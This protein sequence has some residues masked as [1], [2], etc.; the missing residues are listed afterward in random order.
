MFLECKPKQHPNGTMVQTIPKLISLSAAVGRARG[1]THTHRMCRFP[2]C[3]R[4]P[5][6]NG[7]CEE[8]MEGY[9]CHC[10]AEVQGKHCNE[11][12]DEPPVNSLTDDDEKPVVTCPDDIIR[13]V[14]P[15]VTSLNVNFPN[16]TATDNSGKASL[17]RVTPPSGSLFQLGT[18]EVHYVFEDPSGNV[19]SCRFTVTVNG[20]ADDD[21]H[22]VVTCPDDTIRY[23]VPGV[24]SLNVTFPN[25]TATDNSGKASVIRVIPPSGS[26][27][28]LG[29]TEVHYVFEDPSWNIGACICTVS[30]TVNETAEVANMS[31]AL[32]MEN[33]IIPGSS[34]SASS[35]FDYFHSTAR[36]RLNL[37]RLAPYAGAWSARSHDV[38]PWIQVDLIT[39]YRINE[40]GT[41]G[42]EDLFQWVTSY[43][44]SCGID[45]FN[46]HIVK[47]S[48]TKPK[49]DKVFIGNIDRNTV[50]RNTLP[51]PAVCRY[52]RLVPITYH[53]HVSLRM[54]L[55]GYG[56]LTVGPEW[57]CT[58]KKCY[59]V[60]AG[61][62]N[63]TEAYHFCH[64]LEPVTTLAG[65]KRPSL[66]F[67]NTTKEY[68][69]VKRCS[70][71]YDKY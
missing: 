61:L 17:I 37:P 69:V 51:V 62:R 26:L 27:F 44:I 3:E 49:T 5:C 25:A 71:L 6:E 16:A 20:T 14:V 4:N 30:V 23:V 55:Y 31:Y 67:I 13:Y 42:R 9:K 53:K 63:W 2:D 11:H 47:N 70:Y 21:E 7:W 15:G 40:V 19:G 1:S 18:T 59:H 60:D 43:K 29:T 66:L 28:Q 57:R 38:T 35:V 50:V 34:L 68:Q 64:D 65:D 56:P 22:P 41:Q 36:A 46:H 45:G 10:P 52:V 8:T 48:S 54:E 39:T 58:P 24:T 32:G 33:G 12:V